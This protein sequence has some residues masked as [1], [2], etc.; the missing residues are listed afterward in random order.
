MLSQTHETC[1]ELIDKINESAEDNSPLKNLLETLVQK[2]IEITGTNESAESIKSQTPASK[3]LN[4]YSNPDALQM[5]E[6]ISRMERDL[7]CRH[8]TDCRLQGPG[9]DT[10][11][12]A[13]RY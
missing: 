9:D 1:L 3:R 7:L 4:S 10:K 8:E 5:Y 2:Y 6:K 13:G 12:T 11:A